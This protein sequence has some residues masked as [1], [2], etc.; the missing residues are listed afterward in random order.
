MPAVRV[1]SS[2][3]PTS[4]ASGAVV[5]A[6]LVLV[7]LGVGVAVAAPGE[8]V[9]RAGGGAREVAGLLPGLERGSSVSPAGAGA[10]S[11]AGSGLV[12][13]RGWAD[14]DGDGV[15]DRVEEALC[16]SGTCAVP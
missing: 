11:F 2:A 16:G 12:D 10:V 9:A 5:V 3:R 1:S 7:V 14:V 6:G 13:R 4:P 15:A 8:V